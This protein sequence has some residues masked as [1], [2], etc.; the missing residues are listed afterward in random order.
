[1]AYLL[2]EQIDPFLECVQALDSDT[3]LIAEV[4]LSTGARWGEAEG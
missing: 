3:L 1:M 2:L 4:C